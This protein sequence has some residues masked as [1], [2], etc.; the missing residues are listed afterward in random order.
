[1]Y[2]DAK[3]ARADGDNY[4]STSPIQRVYQFLYTYVRVR[5]IT[6]VIQVYDQSMKI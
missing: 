1:M 3:V 5:N 4:T 2:L 6:N